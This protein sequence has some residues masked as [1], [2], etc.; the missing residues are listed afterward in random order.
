MFGI[1]LNCYT[2]PFAEEEIEDKTPQHL[3]T[4]HFSDTLPSSQSTNSLSQPYKVLKASKEISARVVDHDLESSIELG[5]D[6]TMARSAEDT[7]GRDLM[8]QHFPKMRPCGD[9][10]LGGEMSAFRPIKQPET[11]EEKLGS[12]SESLGK[13]HHLV[14][15]TPVIQVNDSEIQLSPSSPRITVFP[16]ID[17][18]SSSSIGKIYPDSKM[19]IYII[20]DWGA[21]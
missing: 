21:K 3:A 18:P 11:D 7:T 4:L 1:D 19:P 17:D 13:A 14:K 16:K 6:A 2:L 8:A 20:I 9:L 15:P 5:V 10:K 12:G